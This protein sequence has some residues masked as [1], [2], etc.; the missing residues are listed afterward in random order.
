MSVAAARRGRPAAS[1]HSAR[2]EH[3]DAGQEHID[4][5]RGMRMNTRMCVCIWHVHVH[6]HVHAARAS[7]PLTHTEVHI[8]PY[9]VLYQKT[10]GG[11]HR[12]PRIK[13]TDKTTKTARAMPSSMAPRHLAAPT[14]TPD[15][16]CETRDVRAVRRGETRFLE[17][18]GPRDSHNRGATPWRNFESF[19]QCREDAQGPRLC[20]TSIRAA[21]SKADLC[22]RCPC[23]PRWASHD[24]GDEADDDYKKCLLPPWSMY[25]FGY[26]RLMF[27]TVTHDARCRGRRVAD[28]TTFRLLQIGLGV[29]TFAEAVRCRCGADVDVIEGQAAVASMAERLFGMASSREQERMLITDGLVGVRTLVANGAKYDGIAIDCMVQ[30]IIPVGCKS[31]EFVAG[32]ALLLRPRG[33][34]AQWTWAP[35]RGALANEFRQHFGNVTF[36]SFGNGGNGI[37][38]VRAP[39]TRQRTS[40]STQSSVT[41]AM[42]ILFG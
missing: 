41:K 37:V 26:V 8:R 21:V 25:G 14:F 18:R 11:P 32:L 23:T 9:H 33:A 15:V 5:G 3:I 27:D 20:S 16:L 17:F 40:H 22:K 39:L 1:P 4:A 13:I 2:Q 36:A 10:K 24:D 29:G 31:A 35:D 7:L 30:G 6:V 42:S 34:I 19:I 12:A 38:Q 28:Q